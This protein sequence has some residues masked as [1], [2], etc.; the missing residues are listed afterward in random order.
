MEVVCC[1]GG[2]CAVG[3]VCGRIITVYKRQRS[4]YEHKI[5]SFALKLLKQKTY[6]K[7]TDEGPSCTTYA[8]A[9]LARPIG[10]IYGFCAREPQSEEQE[11]KKH[12]K[13]H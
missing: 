1:G 7:N 11:T 9:T 2:R 4:F 13:D 5:F 10:F 3:E 6:K 12:C 8:R